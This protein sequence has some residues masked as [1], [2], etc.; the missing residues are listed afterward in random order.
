[1]K[2]LDVVKL[3]K[4]YED[5]I[6]GTEGTIVLDYDGNTFEVEFM[7]ENNNTIGVYTIEKEYLE[8]IESFKK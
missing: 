4:N 3:K 6:V 5:L 8:L 7:D 2:E 1:M